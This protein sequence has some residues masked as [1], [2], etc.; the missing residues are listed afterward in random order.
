MKEKFREEQVLAHV[1]NPTQRARIEKEMEAARVGISTLLYSLTNCCFL[2]QLCSIALYSLA[3]LQVA[4][5]RI[6]LPLSPK[7]LQAVWKEQDHL[8]N[9]DRYFSGQNFQI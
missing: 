6:H 7:Q 9:K 1:E 4:M 2:L 5:I 3:P 8:V